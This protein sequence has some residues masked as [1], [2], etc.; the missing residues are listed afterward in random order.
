MKTQQTQDE[1]DTSKQRRIR[2]EFSSLSA[3]DNSNHHFLG[4]SVHF[5]FYVCLLN[6]SSSSLVKTSEAGQS[7][8]DPLD[9]R[10]SAGMGCPSR[11]A[12]HS[13][14]LSRLFPSAT[15]P[16]LDRTSWNATNTPHAKRTA[17]R[18]SR[19]V[20]RRDSS[21]GKQKIL[22]KDGGCPRVSLIQ[23]GRPIPNS[24]DLSR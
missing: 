21:M 23:L 9:T 20:P 3:R 1:T 8:G 5:F 2:A 24:I 17:S 19:V 11:S 13:P 7:V 15:G 22:M 18:N 16:R 6:G 10:D 14:L 12:R 4:G